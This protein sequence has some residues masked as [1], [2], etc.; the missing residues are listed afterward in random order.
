MMQKQLIS[1][2][3]IGLLVSTIHH[4]QAQEV[5]FGA[6]AGL[7]LY[8]LKIE[9]EGTS[10]TQDSKPGFAFGA[11]ALYSINDNVSLQPELLFIQKNGEEYWGESISL[12]YIELPILARIYLPLE[13]TY[14]P[15]FLAGPSVGFLTGA[16]LDGDDV[17]DWFKSTNFG[18]SVGAGAG[19]NNFNFD[20]R[21][22]FGLANIDD[23]GEND[24][25]VKYSTRGL[26]LTVGYLFN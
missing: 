13:T 5:R 12:S 8:T 15:H 9:A 7:N 6:K 24:G 20:L 25:D 11:F 2:F 4:T 21:Y 26:L 1:F 17:S 10:L 3:F 19:Y 18:I 16:S 22:D 23:F 14:S